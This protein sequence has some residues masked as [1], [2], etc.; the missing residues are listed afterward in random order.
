MGASS[1]YPVAWTA[2]LQHLKGVIGGLLALLTRP[3][4]RLA[5]LLQHELLHL[6][7]VLI[8]QGFGQRDWRYGGASAFG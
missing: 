2:V 1:F 3:S 8:E 5:V 4:A 6:V 7:V